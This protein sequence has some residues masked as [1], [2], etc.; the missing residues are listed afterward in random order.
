[1][2]PPHIQSKIK[3]EMIQEKKNR[4]LKI[5][6]PARKYIIFFAIASDFREKYKIRFQNKADHIYHPIK[7]HHLIHQA[8]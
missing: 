1:M 7:T 8:V 5:I 2:N 4:A 3:L 6:S